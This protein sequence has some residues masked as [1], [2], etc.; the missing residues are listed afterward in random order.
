MILVTADP[1]RGP[2]HLGQRFVEASNHL[3]VKPIP[4]MS[5]RV[6]GLILPRPVL[7]LG[8][9]PNQIMTYSGKAQRAVSF[10]RSG[11]RLIA[12]PAASLQQRRTRA[13]GLIQKRRAS[14]SNQ[15]YRCRQAHNR[16]RAGWRGCSIRSALA[17][18]IGIAVPVVATAQVGFESFRI[19][20][21]A[22]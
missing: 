19:I 17:N 9:R 22:F 8:N 7:T 10:G 16:D 1:I 21:A 3:Q 15:Q 2:Q 12:L 11:S 18:R 6:V 20:S 14:C 4:M 5:C 13:K